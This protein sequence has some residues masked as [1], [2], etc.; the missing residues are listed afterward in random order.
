MPSL[1]HSRD[2]Q[3]FPARPGAQLFYLNC[4]D[5]PLRKRSAMPNLTLIP[6]ATREVGASATDPPGFP[7]E[8]S[9]PGKSSLAVPAPGKPAR[10]HIP[11]LGVIDQGQVRLGAAHEAP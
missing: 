3:T 11:R 8:F 6:P 2:H 7:S 4:D 9:G 10:F 5:T 1:L